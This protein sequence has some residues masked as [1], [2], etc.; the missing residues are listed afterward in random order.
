MKRI[1]AICLCGLLFGCA[2]PA[3]QEKYSRT[4]T[5]ELELRHA[6]C[7][8]FLSPEKLDID[9]RLGPPLAMAMTDDGR[10]DRIKEKKEIEKELLRRYQ[11][12]DKDAYRPILR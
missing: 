1:T 10:T 6:Q 11:A 5:A 9:I 8:Q 2:T 4:S 12:G 3:P 7:V